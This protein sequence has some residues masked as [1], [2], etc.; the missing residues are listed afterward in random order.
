MFTDIVGYTALMARDEEAAR[1]ARDRHEAAV[2][3]LV[4]RYHGEWA[5]LP[6]YVV[7]ATM[8]PFFDTTY[9]K[10]VAWITKDHYLLVHALYQDETGDTLREMTANVETIGEFDGVWIAT[11]STMANVKR[12]TSSTLIV[13]GLEAN[14]PLADGLFSSFRL[15][16]RG[17]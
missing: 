11:E 14:P 5:G 3:P 16:E 9:R 17:P 10:V 2:R 8:Q 1:R 4:E 15:D 12:A 6:V 13:Q 7:N